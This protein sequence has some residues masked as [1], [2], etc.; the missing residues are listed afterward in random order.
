MN[1]NTQD[2]L[3]LFAFEYPPVS[4]GIARL[5][6]EIRSGLTRDHVNGHVLTQDC[7]APV[8]N[9][10]LPEVRVRSKRPIREWR[11]FQWLR[12]QRSKTPIIC[13]VWYPEGLIAYLSGVRPLVILTHGAELLPPVDRWRRPLWKALQRRVLES[14]SLVIANSEYTRQLVSRVAPNARVETIPLAVDPQRFA[15]RNREAAK[16]KYGVSGK[17]VLCTVSRMYPYKGHDV[18]LR[19]IASLA[20]N[21]R[22]QLIYLVVGKGPY[23]PRLRKL[24][25]ELRVESNVRWLGFVAEDDLPEV[26]SASDLFVL[27][28]R[29]APEERCV[30][31]FGLV[32]LEAQSCGTPVVGTRTGGIPAAIQDGAGGWLIGQDDKEAL[33]GIIRTLVHSPELFRAAGTQARQRVLREHTWVHYM[34]RF[35][36]ALQD[37]GISTGKYTDGVTV[38][39]PTLN[40]GPYLLDTL[41]DLLAQTHRPIEILVVDQS[42]E[43]VPALRDLV[44]A[45]SDVISYHKVRFRGLPLAR[46]YGWQHAKYEAIVFVDDDIRCGPELVSEHLRGLTQPDIGMV[47]GGIDEPTSSRESSEPG[48]FNSWTATPSRGFDSTGEFRVSHVP[49][50]NFSAWR[51]VLQSAGGFDEALAAG[52]ALYEETELCLRVRKGGFDILFRG[53]AR[54]QHLAAGNGGCRVSDLPKYISCL[55]HNRAVLI[56]RNLRWFQVPI[57]CLRLLLLFVSYAAHY[58]TFGIFRPGIAGFTSGLQAAKQPPI[59]S[60]YK[61]AAVHA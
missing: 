39:V 4:G 57:A 37:A 43:E 46:N 27:C 12:K 54:L 34:Q 13:G 14:A 49:G 58:R 28:T 26:Y 47:A 23:E 59:C 38:V 35:L 19:A 15:P 24:A 31:G 6:A 2:E 32:F 21:E 1:A 44:R 55:A 42:M 10:G 20:P 50:G 17:H 9:D 16:K 53:S 7:A 11:A 29:D 40:R 51:S 45:H 41:Q 52:A 5:C 48:Q 61:S 8:H 33:A 25:A 36:S 22:E 18:V 3:L 56:G 60:Q 30:E